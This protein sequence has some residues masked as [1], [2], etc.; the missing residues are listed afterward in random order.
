[1]EALRHR[2]DGRA[3][4]VVVITARQLSAEDCRR[5]NGQVVRI[6]QKGQT[7][8]EEVLN[9]V[10]RLMTGISPGSAGGPNE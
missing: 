1:M 9:E 4:P 6:I 2:E 10:R 8:A 3:I 5:L 7:T